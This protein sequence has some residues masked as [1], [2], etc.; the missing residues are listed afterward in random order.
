MTISF[1]ASII[2]Q[3]PAIINS[4]MKEASLCMRKDLKEEA[5]T[6]SSHYIP[7][8]IE[9]YCRNGD[10]YIT[11]DR[12]YEVCRTEKKG[13]THDVYL[14][15]LREQFALGLL[16]QEGPRIYTHNTWLCEETAARKLAEL[17]KDNDYR[18]PHLRAASETSGGNVLSVE[19]Q[20][21]VDMSLS[22]RLSLILGGAGTGKSTLIRAIVDRYPGFDYVICAPTGKAARNLS[23]RTKLRARTV[24]SAC[25]LRPDDDFEPAVQ[26]SQTG[27]VIVDEAS[28]LSVELLAHVLCRMP[29]TCNL[30]LIGDPNQL[31]SVGPGNVIPDLLAL[32]FPASMLTENYRQSTGAPS[33][34]SN[35]FHFNERSSFKE[36]EWDEGFQFIP[37]ED[38]KLAKYIAELAANHYLSRDNSQVLTTYN[39]ST[40]FSVMR[41]NPMVRE[42]VNPMQP[43]KLVISDGSRLFRDG[44]RVM[45]TKN[46]RERDC[47]NGD[48]GELH[49][50]SVEPTTKWKWDRKKEEHV[51]VTVDVFNFSVHLDDGRNPSW[52]GLEAKQA[53]LLMEL[54]YVIT[55]HKSQGSQYDT[56]FFPMSMQMQNMLSRNLFYTAISRATR[57]VCI[58]GSVQAVD[59]AMQRTLPS[60]KS[61]L[62]QKTQ[63]KALE[64]A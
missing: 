26:W 44:D 34:F 39:K 46:D 60:R 27:L 56:V 24:H 47:N 51:K 28:M 17:Q 11:D 13:L 5:L 45:I 57:R 49:I 16:H 62:V 31:Q 30:V 8:V 15:D 59:V 2:A 41:L 1:P 33:L 7:V 18:N 53:L 40:E 23:E 38:E 10:A 4:K 36:L 12:L 3:F 25:G 42:L 14:R 54:A 20:N 58:F 61:A 64:V 37:V 52:E 35:V 43:G 22:H 48:V 63:M 6:A 19:Q 21:A 55:V 29:K 32:G 50:S 9:Q